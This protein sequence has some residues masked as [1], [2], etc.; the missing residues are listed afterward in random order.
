[1]TAV[2]RETVTREEVLAAQE[3]YRLATAAGD[4]DAAVECFT[5]DVVTGNNVRGQYYG[6]EAAITWMQASPWIR[7]DPPNWGYEMLWEILEVAET[8][9]RLVTKW[10]HWLPEPRPD[11]SRYEF[12]GV[13]EKVYAGNGQFSYNCSILDLAG[14][15]RIEADA[16]ADGRLSK[17]KDR[18]AHLDH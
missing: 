2:D 14:L 6:R 9:A 13:T 15:Q 1:M 18:G 10:K 16:I 11:R 4:W 7:L 12:V 8:P 5:E 17:F 3:R